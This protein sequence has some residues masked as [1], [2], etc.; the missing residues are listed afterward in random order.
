[1][2]CFNSILLLCWIGFSPVGYLISRWSQRA[3]CGRWTRNDRLF[4]IVFS[5]ITGPFMI[6]GAL[7][8][9]LL[10]HMEKSE[11]GNQEARW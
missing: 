1:M 10:Y 2:T 4:A 9:R 6:I 8:T 3:M 7:A 5:L 11:R